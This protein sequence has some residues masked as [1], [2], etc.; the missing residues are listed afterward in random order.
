[1]PF[2]SLESTSNWEK[3]NQERR[4]AAGASFAP[5][6]VFG[7]RLPR[8]SCLSMTHNRTA[9]TIPTG[10][11]PETQFR[12]HPFPL[13]ALDAQRWRRCSAACLLIDSCPVLARVSFFFSFWSFKPGD[14]KPD[15]VLQ[16]TPHRTLPKVTV[17][18]SRIVCAPYFLTS[19]LVSRTCSR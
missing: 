14:M 8:C 5:V 1:M 19:E 2:W 17:E 15:V 12:S 10:R 11:S 13:G 6:G 3:Q 4:A 7:S 18:A 9:K 16:E